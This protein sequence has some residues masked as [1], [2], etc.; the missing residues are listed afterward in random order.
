MPAGPRRAL[1]LVGATS[2]CFAKEPFAGKASWPGLDFP[3]PAL[4]GRRQWDGCLLGRSW[5]APEAVDKGDCYRDC[6]ISVERDP[7]GSHV[8]LAGGRRRT[9]LEAQFS[10]CCLRRNDQATF[11]TPGC[12]CAWGCTVLN[13]TWFLL[14]VFSASLY[15]SLAVVCS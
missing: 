9:L 3:R 1:D 7:I 15:T 6:F 4:G 14:C 5:A 10:Y 11:G 12:G 13:D 8:F 2:F